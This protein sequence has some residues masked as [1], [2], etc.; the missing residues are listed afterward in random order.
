MT[1]NTGSVP[2]CEREEAEEGAGHDRAGEGPEPHEVDPQGV[3]GRLIG[4]SPGCFHWR[5]GRVETSAL[6][7]L[8][9][10]IEWKGDQAISDDAAKLPHSERGAGGDRAAGL[11]RLPARGTCGVQSSWLASRPVVGLVDACEN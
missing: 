7:Y 9:A 3:V 2:A 6:W 10:T 5:R 11:L 1:V 4:H 8:G